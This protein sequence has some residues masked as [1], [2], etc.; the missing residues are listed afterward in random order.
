MES[1]NNKL[2]KKNIFLLIISSQLNE[3][4]TTIYDYANKLVIASSES[5]S[6]YYMRIYQ[7]SEII[8]QLLFSLFGGVFADSKNKKKI[9]IVTD[10]IASLLTFIVF[11]FYSESNVYMLIVTNICLA[12]LY[13]FNAP[14]YRAIVGDLLSK[15][16]I[17]KYNSYSKSI[18]EFL[19]ILSPVIGMLT[20]ALVG[21]KYGMLVNS[22]SFLL[23]G[24]LSVFFTELNFFDNS[25]QKSDAFSI[26]YG[27]SYI[28]NNKELLL[29]LISSSMINF[30]SSGIN[31]YLPF[32]NKIY[33]LD[34]LYGMILIGQAV[35]NI[36]GAVSNNFFKRSF[37]SNQYSTF[38]LISSLPLIMI[39]LVKIWS[40]TLLLF[41]LSSLAMTIFNV[42]MLSYLQSTIEKEYLGRVF[43][44]IAFFALMLMPLGTVV[45]SYFNFK[46]LLVFGVVGVGDLLTCILLKFALKSLK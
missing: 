25:P 14:A 10:F 26:K 39:P 37:S 20:I 7:F 27:F 29:L 40:I 19:S 21:Y 22:L 33:D 2:E 12:I 1:K 34:K 43:S 44:I 3:F 17:I 16:N 11:M 45:F 23:S 6:N 9:L 30:F 32:I 28:Y 38:L 8:I 42:Q 36:I 46:T 15:N 4:G 18:S 13:A 24:C 5:K 35:G 41:S 31:F